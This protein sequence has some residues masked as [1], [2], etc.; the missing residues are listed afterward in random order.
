VSSSQRQVRWTGRAAILAGTMF[1]LADLIDLSVDSDGF[2]ADSFSGE[3]LTAVSAIQSALT[4][5][6]GV[7]LLVSLAGLYAGRLEQFGLLGLFGFVIAF[8]GTVMAVGAFWA[9]AFVAP[10]LA[11]EVPSLLEGRPPRALA[12]GFTLSYGSTALGWLLFGLAVL[13]TD[14]YPRLAVALLIVGAALTWLP[15]PLSGVPFSVAV[16]WMGYALLPKKDVSTRHAKVYGSVENARQR[17]SSSR[18]E[19]GRLTR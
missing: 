13:R 3:A 19:A 16:V 12:A 14:C 4:L 10:S 17:S 7:L 9:D 6:A 5:G 11:R 2:G 15:L 18:G 8:C 1:I